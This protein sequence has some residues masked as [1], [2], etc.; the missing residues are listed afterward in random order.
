MH[1]PG[2]RTCASVSFCA[3]LIAAGLAGSPQPAHAQTRSGYALSAEKCGPFPKLRIT[4]RAGYCAGLVASK[5]DGLIFPRTIVQ[6]PDTR[7][8]VIAD[9]GGWEPKKGRLL[10]L[11]PDAP[12]GKRIKVLIRGL[13]VPH[14]LGV[15]IDR[16]IYAGVV[17]R[18]FRF[19]PLAADPATT[20][21]TI[22]QGLPGFQP[23]LANGTRLA[24]NA[25][26][27]KNFAFDRTGRIFVNVGAPSDACATGTKETKPCAAGEGASPLAAVWMFTPPAG[28][29]FPA[30]K[31][32]DANPPHEVYA[33]GL[34][35]SMALAAH[36]S[37]PD[38]GFALL[39]GENARDLPDAS[40]PNEEINSLERG[41]HY[42]WPYCYDLSTVSAEYMAFL[43]TSGPYR[44]LCANTALYR[45]P[46]SLMPPHGAPLGMLYYQADKFAD[47]K[48]KLIVGLHGYRP[49][50][51]R[52]I[53]YDTDANG[54]PNVAPPPVRY[55][56]SCGMPQAFAEN[57]KPVA[58][59]S[60]LELISGWHKVNGVR[61]QGAPVGMTVAHDGALW[62]AE[63]KNQT[64]IRI[65]VD[66]SDT[67]DALPCNARTPA[68]ISQLA[69]AVMKNAEQRK[70][71]DAVR[72]QLVE[73]HCVGCHANFDI[74]P[75]MTDKQKDTAVLRFILA[76]DGWV[77]PGDAEAGRLHNR[78][79]GKGAEK[80]MP[81]DG[82]Q[83]LANDP[84]YK[85][86]LMTLDAF[87][88]QM[89]KR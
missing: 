67:P 72:V 53:V 4:M 7:F 6:V 27:L 78:V 76:Q 16:R 55:N 58:A 52:I 81:A 22:I 41:K 23:V 33:R 2:H 48:G 84:S 40:K 75:G 5:E 71:L 87:V 19:D 74:K 11:D 13:D 29:V 73:K 34:R 25:H 9:M 85:V 31:A 59:A 14:G 82:R 39:Q 18:I 42:G 65:D 70:R 54:F 64:I 66:A 17:D 45:P 63:D 46:H 3:A 21:E 43:K 89:G 30:L 28:G 88:T 49:T 86:L 79:W 77:Y 20:V 56:V 10:L 68:Q 62:L 35:N 83:L 37:F 57:G 51:S 1:V 15:G 32:R 69:N 47:L 26:P 12:E 44:E 61:P 24:R 80:I 60:Y 38:A 8:F 50:G 36:P